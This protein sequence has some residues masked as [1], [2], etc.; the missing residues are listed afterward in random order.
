MCDLVSRVSQKG[1]GAGEMAD[2]HIY[3]FEKKKKKSGLPDVAKKTIF[4]FRAAHM[5]KL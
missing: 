3:I 1:N 4:L 2:S 5:L